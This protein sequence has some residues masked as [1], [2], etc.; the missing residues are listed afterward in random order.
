[1]AEDTTG[2]SA[3]D[4]GWQGPPVTVDVA[5][6]TRTGSDL[7]SVRRVFGEPYDRDG[8][9][10]IPVAIVAG[11]SGGGGGTGAV[12]GSTDIKD[13]AG[14]ASTSGTGGGAGFA[15]LVKPL[16]VY[17]VSDRGVRWE[18]TVDLTRVILGGQ[19]V[20]TVAVVALS[21]ALRRRRRRR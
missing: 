11:S 18:P 21:C 10:V 16:G 12:G 20:L 14:S 7:L 17:V 13:T 19:A 6:V 3:E 5:A 1:M 8:T 15:A 9:Q 4:A 2:A